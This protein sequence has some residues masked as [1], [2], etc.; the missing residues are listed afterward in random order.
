[1]QY[2]RGFKVSFFFTYGKT[3]QVL[4]DRELLG[5]AVASLKLRLLKVLC[6]LLRPAIAFFSTHIST[7]FAFLVAVIV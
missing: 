6:R 1:M 5:E 3:H 2:A 7:F 4:H